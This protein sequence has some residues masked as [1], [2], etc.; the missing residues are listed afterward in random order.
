MP[1]Q[2]DRI[3]SSEADPGGR[4]RSQGAEDST[5]SP[6][7]EWDAISYHRVSNP[8]LD[9]GRRV[10]GRLP[11]KGFETVIDAGCGTG[12][13]TR[14]LLERLPNG[15]VIAIDQSTSMIDAAQK[16][17]LPEFNDRVTFVTCNLLNLKLENVADVIFSN[18]TFHWILDHDSLFQTLINALKPDGQLVA[19]CGAEA[20]LTRLLE[21]AERLCTSAEFQPFFAGWNGPWHFS[22][23]DPA[24]SRMRRAGFVNVRTGLEYAPT[25]LENL[26]SYTEFVRTVVFRLHLE[27][28]PNEELR[29]RWLND[30]SERAA[31]DK[32][33]FLLD[34]WRLNLEG[35][36]PA[37]PGHSR[38]VV[39]ESKAN[40][41]KRKQSEPDGHVAQTAFPN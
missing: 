33:P 2:G 18:A 40:L 26:K 9:W 11:L 34:Y 23:P 35:R 21:R 20:N 8:Q 30:L 24:A 5:S 27:R 6:S 31:G 17:L 16:H 19:Q 32:P 38:P 7:V 13:L 37:A 15:H 36:K 14:L 41:E 3:Q 25:V 29:T 4:F 1:Q 39:G 22:G 28:L 10:L 12:R